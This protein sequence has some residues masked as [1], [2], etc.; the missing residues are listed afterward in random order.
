MQRNSRVVYCALCLLALASLAGC[1]SCHKESV[2]TPVTKG[3]DVFQTSTEAGKTTSVDFAANPLPPDFFCPG[4]PAFNG[5]VALKGKQL[6]PGKDFDTV[7]ERLNEGSFSGGSTTIPVK[8]RALGLTSDAP[9][10]INCASGPTNWQMDVCLCG[11]QPTT[12]IVVKVEPECGCGTF[13][14]TLE[15]KTCLKFTNVASGQGAGPIPQDVKLKIKKMPWC[16][17]PMTGS[18]ETGPFSVTDCNGQTE[19]LPGTSNFFPGLTC[20]EQ[21]PGVDC[22]TKFKDLTHCHEGPSPDHQHCVNP[23]CGKRG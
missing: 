17:K 1:H 15:L 10:S 3:V 12:D 20:A 6:V 7:V 2:V 22:W 16:P 19:S 18:L 23:V 14:G 9:I 13:D 8:V 21:K 4:S 11:N 5:K